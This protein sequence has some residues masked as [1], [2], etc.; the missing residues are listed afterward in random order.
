MAESQVDNLGIYTGYSIDSTD[1]YSNPVKK[2][3]MARCVAVFDDLNH[4]VS[5]FSLSVDLN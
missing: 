5:M 4:F 1:I 2:Y 3:Y